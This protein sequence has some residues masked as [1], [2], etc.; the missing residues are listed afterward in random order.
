VRKRVMLSGL[1]FCVVVA[2][3]GLAAVA[4]GKSAGG[5]DA[6]GK[7]RAARL[8]RELGPGVSVALHHETG[9]VR[10]IGTAPGQPIARRPGLDASVSPVAAARAFLNSYGREFGLKAGSSTLRLIGTADSPSGYTAVR[11]QQTIGGVPVLAGELTVDV[12]PAANVLSAIGEVEPGKV[13]TSANVGAAEARRTAIAAVAKGLPEA[14]SE[15]QATDPRL[16]IYD[17]RLLGGPGLDV[18]AL[19]WRTEVSSPVD[20]AVRV[21]V[22]VDATIG[23]VAE[24]IDL[25][26]E[27]KDRRVCDAGNTES[28]V[29]CLPPYDREEG[30]TATGNADID[31]AYDY[32]G[33]TYD[34]YWSRFGRD[35]LNGAGLPLISTVRFCEVPPGC[36]LENAFWNGSQMVYGPGF[37]A[38][39]DVVGH[40]LSHGFTDFTSHLFYWYQSGAINE[41]MSDV[42]GEYIDLTN[43]AGT[44]TPGVRW[45]LGEDIP[46]IGAIRDMQDPPGFGDPD[47]MTSPLYRADEDQ[48]DNGGVHINSGVNNKAAYLLADG[49]TFN[50]TTVTRIG[51]D[52][53]ARIYHDVDTGLLTSG[54]DYADLYNA[55]QQ[56][57]TNAIGGGEGITAVDCQEV[58]DAVDATEMNQLPLNGP[59]PEAPVC[60]AGQNRVNL[61]SDDLESFGSG[62]WTH[63]P[64]F[65]VDDWY[66]PQNLNPYGFD[67]TY[68]TS[69]GLNFWGHN[70]STTAD[71]VM[72][73]TAD[74]A[75]PEGTT[76]LRF[77]HSHAFEDGPG[78]GT[79]YDG[80]QLQYS[81][82]GGA[83]WIDAGPLFTDNGYN[84]TVSSSFGNPIGGQAAFTAE[85]NG[86]ISSRV[87]LSSL[88]GQNVRFRFRIGTDSS[89]DDYGWFIDD[90]SV[91][92]CLSAT[93]PPGEEGGGG[94]EGGGGSGGGGAGGGGARIGIANAGAVARV[95][96]GKA[97]LKLRC[98]GAGACQ[99]SL[100]LVARVKAGKGKNAKASKKKR[101][102]NLVVGRAGFSIAAGRTK[103]IRVRLTGKGKRLVRRAGKRGLKVKLRGKGVANRAV[104]LKLKSRRGKRG[105]GKR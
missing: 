66:Y 43:G 57:C 84:G 18:P 72:A 23:A 88:A 41:S 46:G 50:G 53:A 5:P 97:F 90:I 20:P 105:K 89:V 68:A 30:D 22:L 81:T 63:G 31:A 65:G 39:D 11:L 86:Y 25:I 34:F 83:S 36:P 94:G 7:D 70:R 93:P 49:D 12:D 48:K 44:D 85:S 16:A 35:S 102:R 10:F 51:I 54:S 67:A 62:N 80:G 55:L 8:E 32:A 78:N 3:G 99:G 52:K 1:V 95:K 27:A 38:A 87:D 37:A 40:E 101:V 100:K 6:S 104:K 76:Y 69:G 92:R 2:A 91:Y 21:L 98:R 64:L 29:P 103:T 73:R 82:D 17:S 75:I 61:F 15:L 33:D 24:A 59:A 74:L 13:D 26:E 14:G 9:E 71:F 28:D 58:T 45:E 60:G 77:S 56:A 42:F 96:G 19:V 79:R 47:R 4:S